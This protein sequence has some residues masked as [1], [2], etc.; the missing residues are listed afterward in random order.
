MATLFPRERFLTLVQHVASDPHTPG[1]AAVSLVKE[2][3]VS[4]SFVVGRHAE[5]DPAVEEGHL[6]GRCVRLLISFIGSFEDEMH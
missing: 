3:N 4:N 6:I 2:G 1:E 5:D